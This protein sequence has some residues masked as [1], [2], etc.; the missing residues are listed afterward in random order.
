MNPLRKFLQLLVEES[1]R[2]DEMQVEQHLFRRP[3]VADVFVGRKKVFHEHSRVMSVVVQ[4]HRLLPSYSFYEKYAA[5]MD[6]V[7]L[8][9]LAKQLSL[10]VFEVHQ[11]TIVYFL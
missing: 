2:V 4:G 10:L 11:A 7:V 8:H 9:V 6:A 1:I 5:A 3:D